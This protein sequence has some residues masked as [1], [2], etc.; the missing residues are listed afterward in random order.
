MTD[1]TRP[2]R[3]SRRGLLQGGLAVG[4]VSV[5]GAGAAHAA[6]PDPTARRGRHRPAGDTEVV[7][8]GVGGGPTYLPGAECEGISSALKVGDRY[9]L[10]DAG[11]GVLQRLRQ[12]ELGNW[13]VPNGGPLDALR[14]VFVTH[15]HSD[16]IVDLNNLFVSGVFNGLQ[17]TDR[18]VRLIGP[19]N[20]GTLPPVFGGGPRG[21][22]VA[23]EN[24][25]PGTVETW[26]LLKRCFATDYNDRI[27]DNRIEGPDELVEAQDIELPTRLTADPNG[28][29][30]PDMDPV[31]IYEDDRVSVS[32]I[33]VQHAPV[34]PAFAYRFETEAGSVV[35]SGDTSR[36]PNIVK[37]ASQADVLVHEV[38]SRQWLDQEMPEPRSAQVQAGYQHLLGAHTA[39]EEVG[40]VA[41]EA[42]VRRLVLNHLVPMNWPVQRWRQTVSPDFSGELFVGQDLMRIPVA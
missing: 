35:F 19:G 16:H 5:N 37:L 22:V 18:P 20:R 7:L 24:P 8:L 4:A 9:Y 41:E 27:A 6:A 36:T 13:A 38:I 40:K 23:P 39:A 42:G 10:V 31:L 14:A 33:L 3:F 29:N 26:E 2:S 12:A 32:C 17:F 25:T 34:F 28:S 30:V 15:L 21:P 11:H 1:H